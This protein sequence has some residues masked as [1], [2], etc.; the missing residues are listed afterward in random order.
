MP[1]S[2]GF[3]GGRSAA[4]AK[5]ERQ[6][7]QRTKAAECEQQRS[8]FSSICWCWVL[9]L[10]QAVRSSGAR[11]WLHRDGVS[12]AAYFDDSLPATKRRNST[13]ILDDS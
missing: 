6:R 12:S 5:C 2:R 9:E 1:E 10:E 8:G 11:L 7:H 4:A 13:V 3:C